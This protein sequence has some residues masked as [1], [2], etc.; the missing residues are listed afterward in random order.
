MKFTILCEDD[1]S[2][3]LLRRFLKRR[4]HDIGR[5]EIAPTG[6]GCGEQWVRKKFP[7]EL[8]AVRKHGGNLIVCTDADKGAVSE[9][10]RHLW[11]ECKNKNMALRT[12]RDTVAFTIPKRNIE[13][14][15]EYF[16]GC[17]VDENTNYAPPNHKANRKQC[18][19]AAEKLDEYYLRFCQ[20]PSPPPDP[21]IP[22]LNA[23]CDEW[24]R[25]KI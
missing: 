8:A 20:Q 5:E 3:C 6:Q 23:A 21:Q 12:Q 2:A 16:L 13:T 10:M 11:E 15:I 7:A 14:W 24:R 18:K 17:N 25:L 1:Q 22:S 19:P 4:G 9:R